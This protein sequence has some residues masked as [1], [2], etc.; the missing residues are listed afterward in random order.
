[1]SVVRNFLKIQ[2]LAVVA[3]VLFTSC[4]KDEQG[5]LM[6]EHDRKM[7]EMKI[8]YGFTETDTLPGGYGIYIKYSL[9]TDSI[10]KATVNDMIVVDYVGTKYSGEIFDLS[11]LSVAEDEGLYDDEFIYGPGRFWVSNTFPGFQ[12]SILDMPVGS[13]AG[14][15]VPGS[16]WNGYYEPVYYEVELYQII[17]DVDAYNELM[18]NRYLD[19]LDIPINDT[20]PGFDGIWAKD[21]RERL[22]DDS[23]AYGDTVIVKLHG[24][25]VEA[26]D[27]YVTDFPGRQFFPIASSGDSV[28]FLYGS[29]GPEIF[30]YTLAVNEAVRFM[31]IGETIDMVTR[32]EFGY[33]ENGF[34]H[35]H[36]GNYIVPSYMPLHYT[37]ELID[38]MKASE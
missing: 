18:I 2:I 32:D 24:Y 7:N 15:L 21:F 22:P 13:K 28:I 26:D 4:L 11:R 33:G 17:E 6:A 35:P 31:E 29:Y 8:L 12:L 3:A 19:S 10:R 23:I 38:I 9:K 36:T 34:I 30:P 5:E 27:A 20:M 1:M 14:I 37:I 25:Y 16:L